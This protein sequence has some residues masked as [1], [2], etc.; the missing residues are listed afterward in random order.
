M[1]FDPNAHREASLQGWEEAAPGWT[2]QQE[3]LR[4]FSAPVSHWM[5]DAI[6]PQPGWRVL[7][8]AAG[9]GETGM[10]AAELV[11]PM[12]GV[13]VSDQA[14]AMLASARERAA[15]LGLSNVEFQVLNA[16]WIDLPVA[17][18]D[19]VLCRWG[20]MLLADPL[21]AL[22]ETRRVL[23]PGGCLAFAVWDAIEHNPWA[24]Q[25]GQEL[26]E[27]GL[28]P[29]APPGTPGPFSL[30]SVEEVRRLLEK[31]GFAEIAVETIGLLRRHP[32]F[33]DL[34]ETTLDL[35]RSFHDAVLSR[36]PGEIEEIEQAVKERF[37]PYEAADGSLEVPA[38]TIVASASA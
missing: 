1:S 4:E 9:L 13:V 14:E 27:R 5:I 22:I 23:R 36:P 17:S 11:A 21:A 12:G 31:A 2:R 16:E 35:S 26:R 6:A 33:T 28:L 8:L 3:A 19:A 20:Y 29:L 32:G 34:W 10:L 24:L 30:G 25:P 7:E 38:R 15:Q 18:V 37:A